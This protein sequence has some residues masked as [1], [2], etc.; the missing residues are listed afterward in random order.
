MDAGVPMNPYEA[1]KAELDTLLG[2]SMPA[3]LADAIAGRYQFT[4]GEVMDES[5]R[6]IKGMKASF[7]GAAV[8]IGLIYLVASFVVGMAVTLAVPAGGGAIV[9]QVVNSVLNV[10]MTPFIAG[11]EMMCVRRALGLPV[12]FGTAFGYFPK[13]GAVLGGAFLVTLFAWLGTLALII[14]GIYLIV[15]YELVTKLICDQNLSPWRAM[16]TSRKAITRRWWSVFGLGL[17]VALLTG[18]S[19]LVL[20]PLI[21][22]V[23]WLMMTTAVLYRRMFYAQAPVADSVVRS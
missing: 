9:R 18:V 1:P 14:P 6:L 16:E 11:L 22:T 7:W 15:G 2:P 4:V 10:L 8:L 20:V 12:S 5:W 23:P 17:L 3:N 21:W 13:L 19:G